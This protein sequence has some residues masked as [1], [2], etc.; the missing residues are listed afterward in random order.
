MAQLSEFLSVGGCLEVGV[1]G[2]L[3]SFGQSNYFQ[4]ESFDMIKYSLIK[5]S[6]SGQCIDNLLVPVQVQVASFFDVVRNILLH[7]DVEMSFEQVFVLCQSVAISQDK[8][9]IW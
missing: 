3:I 4:H 9:G 8:T 6:L 5:H 7:F 1:R 2:I